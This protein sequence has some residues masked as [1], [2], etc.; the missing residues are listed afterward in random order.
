MAQS[1]KHIEQKMMN[2]L[3]AK[4]P[5]LYPRRVLA[6]KAP[7]ISNTSKYLYGINTANKPCI[8][9]NNLYFFVKNRYLDPHDTNKLHL[10]K[11]S[12]NDKHSSNG[13]DYYVTT[14]A[15]HNNTFN[16][17]HQKHQ[18]FYVFNLIKYDTFGKFD[19]YQIIRLQPDSLK[20]KVLPN[21]IE[22]P[23]ALDLSQLQCLNVEKDVYLCY[24]Y[25]NT[26]NI[27]M[28][29]IPREEQ[30]TDTGTQLN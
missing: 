13:G 29:H 2:I 11:R 30:N 1:S 4:D 3:D 26:Y 14:I 9:N 7:K 28:L 22:L 20:T 21:S 10:Y 23:F 24:N 12:I 6:T 16:V 15:I 25:N 18:C 19:Q 5:N 27:T 17:W 8:I